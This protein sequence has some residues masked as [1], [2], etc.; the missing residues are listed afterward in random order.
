MLV[1]TRH[2]PQQHWALARCLDGRRRL[3]CSRNGRRSKEQWLQAHEEKRRKAAKLQ[4]MQGVDSEVIKMELHQRR[5]HSTFFL[6]LELE[7]ILC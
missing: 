7:R 1:P 4:A 2:V 3:I 5:R 6:T